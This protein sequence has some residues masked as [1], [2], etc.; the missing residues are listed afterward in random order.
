MILP[1]IWLNVIGETRAYRVMGRKNAV[2][3][4]DLE[5]GVHWALDNR[6][7]PLRELDFD[8]LTRRL[9]A[10]GSEVNWDV[11][12]IEAQLEMATLIE[13]VQDMICVSAQGSLM[14]PAAFKAF[15]TRLR[16]VK[17][18]LF[19]LQHWTL[20]L[21]RRAEVQLQIVSAYHLLYPT[22]RAKGTC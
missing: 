6:M 2:L 3:D 11:L 9:T 10:V 18:V 15:R 17:Q 21:K 5:L 8:K 16:N 22:Y 4:S 14:K 7:R 12:A 19:G 1:V 20:C 13:T